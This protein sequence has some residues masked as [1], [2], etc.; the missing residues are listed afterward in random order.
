ME[1]GRHACASEYTT[2]TLGRFDS[3]REFVLCVP[4]SSSSLLPISDDER[5]ALPLPLRTKMNTTALLSETI[6]NMDFIKM[7][8]DAIPEELQLPLVVVVS[9]TYLLVGNG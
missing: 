8:M 1:G 4:T 2:V 9:H 7:K 3:N 6:V 5:Q